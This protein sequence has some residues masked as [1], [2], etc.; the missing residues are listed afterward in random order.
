[1][2]RFLYFTIDGPKPFDS[3]AKVAFI[4]YMGEGDAEDVD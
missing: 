2:A 3:L 4:W 1:M